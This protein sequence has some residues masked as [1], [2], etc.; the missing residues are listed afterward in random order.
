MTTATPE[1]PLVSVIMP[2][3]NEGA[4]ITRSLGAVI[5]QDYPRDRLEVIVADGMSTDGSREALARWQAIEPRIRV[6]DNGGRTAPCGLNAALR[7]ARGDVIVRVDGHCVIAPDY[8]RRCV[9]HLQASTVDAVGG[10]LDTV[11][12]TRSAGI[13]ACAMSSVFG[14]GNSAFRTTSDKTLAVDTVAFPAYRRSTLHRLGPFDEE[15][16]RNQDDEYNYR[17]RKSGGCVLLAADVRAQ[18]Y[19]RSSFSSV[20]RQFF[21]YGYWKVRVLQKHPYQMCVR[22]FAPPVFVAS[23]MGSLLAAP[24]TSAAWWLLAAVAGAYT[25]ANLFA[26]IRTAGRGHLRA[27][28]PLSVV[29]AIMHGAYGSGFLAGL[30]TFWNRW[31]LFGRSD[32]YENRVPPVSRA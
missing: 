22:Q 23:L 29:F 6:V 11:G 2:V 9:G 21:Q 1:P 26:S 25:I 14:V 31:P 18:Y 27:V 24:F 3:R 32:T 13:I 15:L 16:V 30:F 4:F 5:E 20:W 17:L 8:V 12:E 28:A 10:P 7:V 19:S